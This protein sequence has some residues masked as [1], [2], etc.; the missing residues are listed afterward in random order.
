MGH[1]REAIKPGLWPNIAQL[2]SQGGPGVALD[3]GTGLRAPRSPLAELPLQSL[4]EQGS[5][6]NTLGPQGLLLK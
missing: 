5:P 1:I 2:S 4:D 3:R 6:G